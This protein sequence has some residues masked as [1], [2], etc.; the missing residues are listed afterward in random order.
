MESTVQACVPCLVLDSAVCIWKVR[1][2]HVY[3][4]LGVICVC[5]KEGKKQ[6]CFRGFTITLRH[7]TIGRT[8]WTSDQSEAETSTGQHTAIIRGTHPCN[9][10]T[11]NLQSQEAGDHRPKP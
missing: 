7:T 10:R 3:L 1:Y 4:E 6:H 11:K 9:R 2:K 8:L 5:R